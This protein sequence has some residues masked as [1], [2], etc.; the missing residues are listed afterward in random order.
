MVW[1]NEVLQ[2]IKKRNQMR[3]ALSNNYPN[4]EKFFICGMKNIT[5]IE[6]L[7]RHIIHYVSFV[8]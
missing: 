6:E 8:R 7:C 1:F 3:N 5:K 2:K 4:S